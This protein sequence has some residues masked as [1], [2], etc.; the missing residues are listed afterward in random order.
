MARV[1]RLYNEQAIRISIA[2]MAARESASGWLP[3]A[4]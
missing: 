3:I 4:A 2:R 1:E